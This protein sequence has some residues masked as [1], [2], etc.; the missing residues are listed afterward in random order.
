M[1]LVIRKVDFY[2]GYFSMLLPWM[3]CNFDYGLAYKTLG[4]I[5]YYTYK[6]VAVKYKNEVDE[7]RLYWSL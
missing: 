4:Q 2:F 6:H 5:I 1:R 3:I 7:V